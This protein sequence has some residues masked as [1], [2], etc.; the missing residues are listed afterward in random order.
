MKEFGSQVYEDTAY[1]N[2]D[3][4]SSM[5]ELFSADLDTNYY[6]DLKAGLLRNDF[7]FYYK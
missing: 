3:S 4:N 5:A 1:I 6:A 2:F 7:F